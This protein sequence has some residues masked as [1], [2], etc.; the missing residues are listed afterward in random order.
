MVSKQVVKTQTASN[1]NVFMLS[2]LEKCSLLSLLG[3]TLLFSCKTK[4]EAGEKKTHLLLIRHKLFPI[5]TQYLIPGSQKCRLYFRNNMLTSHLSAADR[6]PSSIQNTEQ[7]LQAHSKEH[8]DLR[9]TLSC[10]EMQGGNQSIKQFT[11]WAYSSVQGWEKKKNHQK[12]VPIK[13]YT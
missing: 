13:F 11:L 10:T 12:C 2:A 6:S 3:S 9:F 1:L 7:T 4:S 8:A 5:Y